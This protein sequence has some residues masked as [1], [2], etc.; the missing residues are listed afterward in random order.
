CTAS[1]ALG[2]EAL[3]YEDVQCFAYRNLGYAVFACPFSLH[4]FFP[5]RNPCGE[6]LFP[7]SLCDALLK[8]PTRGFGALVQIGVHRSRTLPCA[9]KCG[10]IAIRF[11]HS[12]SV[13]GNAPRPSLTR[14]SRIHFRVSARPARKTALERRRQ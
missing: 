12:I 1:V 14:R 13:A 8:Q 11:F 2:H 5:R 10:A 9:V 6:D 3:G 7:Q 4:D